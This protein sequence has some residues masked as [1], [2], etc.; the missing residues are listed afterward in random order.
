VP[1]IEGALGVESI[2]PYPGAA[3]L[4]WLQPHCAQL[5]APLAT[6]TRPRVLCPVMQTF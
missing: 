1:T 2:A 5:Q 4:I 3:F 6:A